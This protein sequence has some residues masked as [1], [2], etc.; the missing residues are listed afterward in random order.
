MP[1]DVP[2]LEPML[3]HPSPPRGGQVEGLAAVFGCDIFDCGFLMRGQPLHVA[4]RE[5]VEFHRNLRGGMVGDHKVIAGVVQFYVVN[6]TYYGTEGG[7][8]GRQ[9]HGPHGVWGRERM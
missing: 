1:T 5:A 3:F 6:L 4:Y 9:G 2:T 7:R 8:E